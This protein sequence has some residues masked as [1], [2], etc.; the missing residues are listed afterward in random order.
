MS[1]VSIA[2]GKRSRRR[3]EKELLATLGYMLSF[4]GHS[5]ETILSGAIHALRTKHEQ[6]SNHGPRA[7]CALEP[8]QVGV[9]AGVQ[10]KETEELMRT[11]QDESV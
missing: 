4:S 8:W 2:C 6:Q 3:R 11:T 9:K 1:K 5:Q 7:V 10:A